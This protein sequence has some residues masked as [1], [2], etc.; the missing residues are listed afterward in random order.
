MPDAQ[1]A[2]LERV[3]GQIIFAARWLMAP[4]YLGLAVVLVLIIVQF[5]AE[6][7]HVASAPLDWQGNDIMVAAL[8]LVDH[9]LVASVIV[10]VMLSGFES[11]VAKISGTEGLHLQVTQLD[12][13]SLKVKIL[14][15]VVVISAID[16]LKLFLEIEAVPEGKLMWLVI[17][18]LTLLGTAAV[19][20]FVDRV[21]E[22]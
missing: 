2:A 8:G 22:H 7:A 10:M 20:A 19:L 16:L 15:S 18:H 6:I 4:L 13:G 21:A 5:Y 14:G 12:I 3:I 11:F 9:V 1:G 17:I